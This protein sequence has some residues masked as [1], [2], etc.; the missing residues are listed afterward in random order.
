[1]ANTIK[2]KVMAVT[3]AVLAFILDVAGYLWHGLMGQP[4]MMNLMYPKFWGSWSMMVAGLVA[5][6]IGAYV[7]GWLFAVTYNL[8][9]KK[10]G[11]K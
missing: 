2:P 7:L 5:S 3:F 10:Y 8:A 4:S 6:V 9:E 1:M 11:K